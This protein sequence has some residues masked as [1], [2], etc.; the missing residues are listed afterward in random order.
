MDEYKEVLNNNIIPEISDI[1][2]EYA[3]PKPLITDEGVIIPPIDFSYDYTCK[4]IIIIGSCCSGKTIIVKD[5]I[6]Q[7]KKNFH[8]IFMIVDEYHCREYEDLIPLPCI[9]NDLSFEWLENLLERQ[10]NAVG[11]YNKT[12]KYPIPNQLLIFEDCLYIMKRLYTTRPDLFNK[13]F[14]KYKHLGISVIIIAY[15]D[16]EI[17]SEIRKNAMLTIFTTPK[18]A[19]INFERVSNGYTNTEKKLVS[20]I[21]R[22]IYDNDDYHKL[23]YLRNTIEPFKYIK[24][25]L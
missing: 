7:N 12:K 18:A 8:N 13:L 24:V 9:N 1:I 16:K 22:K 6:K 23:C 15:D 25:S 10:Q 5:I 2:I 11:S 4:L 20:Y 3:F 19:S 14:N 21:I 17:N